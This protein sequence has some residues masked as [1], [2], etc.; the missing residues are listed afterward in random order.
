MVSCSCSVPM[1]AIVTMS[2]PSVLAARYFSRV[3]SYNRVA[4]WRLT[5]S[6][7]EMGETADMAWYAPFRPVPSGLT[8]RLEVPLSAVVPPCLC[9]TADLRML[10]GDSKL[11][12]ISASCCSLWSSRGDEVFLAWKVVKSSFFALI[13]TLRLSNNVHFLSSRKQCSYLGS[14]PVSPFVTPVLERLAYILP[15]CGICSSQ[16]RHFLPFLR[17]SSGDEQP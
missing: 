16:C 6:S 17:S 4:S 1:I 15:S 10:G 12:L 14:V 2:L 3:T 5:G 8:C 13:Q 11:L 7:G 9:P